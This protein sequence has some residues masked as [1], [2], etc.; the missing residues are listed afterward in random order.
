[1]KKK[2]QELLHQYKL[3]VFQTEHSKGNAEE[4]TQ[5]CLHLTEE[6]LE[7]KFH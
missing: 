5:E 1:M 2:F 4:I 6:I 3:E 7:D